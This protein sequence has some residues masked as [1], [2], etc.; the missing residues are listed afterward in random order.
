MVFGPLKAIW[1]AMVLY[2]TLGYRTKAAKFMLVQNPPSI[3]L[4][5]VAQ[6]ICWLRNTK[7]VIDW[8]NFGW[9][10]LGLKLGQGHPLVSVAKAYEHFFARFADAHFAVTEAMSRYLSRTVGIHALALHDRPAQIFQ[11][12]SDAQRASFLSK[13]EQT[14]QFAK[15]LERGDWRLVVSSTSWTA[16]EDFSLLLDALVGY[17]KR[18]TSQKGSPRILA[19]ITGKGPQ[20]EHYLQRIKALNQQKLLS[21]AVITTVW[22]SS[23]DYAS[24]LGAADLGVSLHQSTSGV[25]LPMKVV[26]M[27]G[28]GLPVVGWSRFESWPELVKEGVNGKGFGSAEELER[29]FVELFAENGKGLKQLRIGATKEG[30]RRWDDE[31]EAVAGKGVFR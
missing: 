12:L 14:S 19:I 17:C 15:D 20:K 11:P 24:L 29:L 1:Q 10:M 6:I 27:F 21:H 22:L 25:D 23:E 16:D 18:A 7:L 31:W 13:F 4:L 3:P 8:H 30:D 2:R 26:D 5:A 9:S 28:T